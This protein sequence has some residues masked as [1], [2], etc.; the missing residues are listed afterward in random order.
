MLP[1]LAVPL[2]AIIPA[3]FNRKSGWWPN[4]LYLLMLWSVAIYNV[5]QIFPNWLP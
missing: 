2:S 3:C 1:I 5:L 4:L